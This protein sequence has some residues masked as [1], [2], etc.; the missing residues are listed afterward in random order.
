MSRDVI[1]N[2]MKTCQLL[3]CS[4]I[5]FL[6]SCGPKD[7]NVKDLVKQTSKD[8]SEDISYFK[9]VIKKSHSTQVNDVR[10]S[11]VK[12]EKFKTVVIRDEVYKLFDPDNGF[13]SL[14]TKVRK[15]LKKLSS[16][17]SPWLP[18]DVGTFVS[19]LPDSAFHLSGTYVNVLLHSIQIKS[20]DG[21]IQDYVFYNAPTAKSKDITR[22]ISGNYNSFLY[23]LDCSGYLNSAISASGAVPGAEISASAKLAM[24]SKKSLF[25]A[26]GV[27]I[28][29]IATAYYG[30]RFGVTLG[31]SERIQILRELVSIPNIRNTD[32]IIAPVGYE[33]LW[34]SNTGTTGFNGKSSLGGVGTVGIGVGSISTNDNFGGSLSISS[35]F[36]SFETYFTSRKK[37]PDFGPFTVGA[38]N[39]RLNSL[40][41]K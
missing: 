21:K 22:F 38:A 36:S 29:P 28:S 16:S 13:F 19:D 34:M 31:D 17:G 37:V 3:L 5:L 9:N 27:I 4:A 25:I 39:S 33:A 14:P 30:N 1:A 35:S 24:E 8:N 18:N 40:V 23:S 10:A 12:T 41:H 7:S 20:I 11:F 26:G 15:N 6:A 32:S 2:I